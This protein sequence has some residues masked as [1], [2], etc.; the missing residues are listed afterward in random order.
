MISAEQLRKR[1]AKTTVPADPLD[2]ELPEGAGDWPDSVR[3]Q[4]LG[5]LKI[6]A[7]LIPIIENS[8][9]D[10]SLLLTQRSA[11]LK[12]HAGQ[13]SF[14]GGRMEAGDE[15]VV[16]TA[17]RETYEE[18]GIPRNRVDIIGYLDPVPTITGYA[19]TPVIGLIGSDVDLVVDRSEVDEVFDVPIGFFAESG[20]RKIVEREFWG[21]IAEMLEFEFQGRRIWGATAFII[22]KLIK[23]IK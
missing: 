19:V 14:P 8:R 1:L 12:H 20:N 9:R 21:G 10:L 16:Q 7:V 5:S 2:I 13:V 17:L 6:A 23:S 4:L 22:E 18:V 15:D 3:E 11:D